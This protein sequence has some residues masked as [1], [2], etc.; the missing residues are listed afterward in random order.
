MARS[1]IDPI[2]ISLAVAAAVTLASTFSRTA[3]ATTDSWTAPGSGNWSN[4]ANWSTGVPAAGQDVNI[5]N[6]TNPTVSYDY[7][8][9]N[10]T[11]NS[12]T[13]N[14]PPNLILSMS[15]NNLTVANETIQ[16]NNTFT[17]SGGNNTVTSNL[18]IYSGAYNLSA[19]GNLSVQTETMDGTFTQS[20]GNHTIS[21]Y[22]L[23]GFS[24]NGTYTLSGD[25][26]LSAQ[27]EILGNGTTTQGNGIF[28]QTGGTNTTGFLQL[29]A[30]N[31][32]TFAG[33]GN[34]TL[35]GNGTLL[36]QGESFG[37][38]G[39]G[40]FT[41]TGGVH[42]VSGTLTVGDVNG[43]GNG[44]YSL[45][46]NAS[47][48]TLNETVANSAS[49]T[50]NQSGGSNTISGTLSIGDGAGAQ[51][52]IGYYALSGNATLSALNEFVGDAFGTGNFTQ[53]GGNNSI[54][55]SLVM[56]NAAFFFTGTYTLSS[57]NLS[58]YGNET[59][60]SSG[61]GNFTQ[62][63]GVHTIAG[64]LT[65]A[66]NAGSSGLF[67]LQNGS[68]ATSS[69]VINSAGN[70]TQSGGTASLGP[71]S[72]AGALTISGGSATAQ[73]LLLS[74]LSLSNTGSLQILPN[75]SNTTTSKISTLT[76][77]GSTSNWTGSLDL[78]N[79]KLILEPTVATKSAALANLQNQSATDAIVSSTLPANYALAV[80]D[81]AVT[82]FTTFG[83][84]PVDAN[85]LLLSPEL[86]GDTN[87]DGKVDLTDLSAVLNNFGQ[88]TP[89]WTDGNFDNQPT[90]DLTD[91]SAV[92]NNFGLT[93]PSA[94]S[95]QTSA[96]SIAPE[97]TTLTLLLTL[98]VWSSA[99]RRHRRS[100]LRH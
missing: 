9:A 77:A 82:N 60:G 35:S 59:L 91:L 96:F 99:F 39:S 81:N 66:A 13:L 51:N 90:I 70:F 10:V 57:G 89:N 55:G 25:G 21:T 94:F 5:A 47:L 36:T 63:G 42:T 83:S 17:Q 87:A 34:Y 3:S 76:L 80:L 23:C 61:V 86:L 73:S 19:S 54:F 62:S 65:L 30:R 68:L 46:G 50:F 33:V 29:G 41:Q 7:T 100:K 26:S 2:A 97:P 28:N 38:G 53:S 27:N 32:A 20:G 69:T 12:L 84:L 4:P 48:S 1:K 58:V 79:N 85:S 11:L 43:F 16:T 24:G 98:P 14:R 75:G 15:A 44:T 92:L 49:G 72:G 74:S 45:S 37:D 40:T 8:G 64:S 22:F 31:P 88:S 67:Q 71:I 52:G 95:L 18:S 78:T 6:G 56:G 93:N